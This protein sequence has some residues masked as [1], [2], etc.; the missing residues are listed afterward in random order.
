MDYRPLVAEAVRRFW[1]VRSRQQDQQGATT[2]R[3]D[4][5]NRTAVT[6]G[7]HLD[8]FID[9]LR[10]ILTDAGLPDAEVHTRVATLPGWFRPTK[11]WDLVVVSGHTLVAVIECK[12]HVGPSFGN[13]FNNRIEEALGSSTDL[14]AAWREGKF[15]PSARP[16][17]GWLML[18]EDTER[19]TSPVRL[20]EPHFPVFP[21]FRQTSYAERYAIF[22]QRLL[23]E[24]LYDGACLLLTPADEG[25]RSGAFSE[26]RQELGFRPFAT[27]LR[28]HAGA[29]A[30][31]RE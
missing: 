24:R 21:E 26:P 20:D 29:F 23:R 1:A 22:C 14:L 11:N 9:L 31:L 2:G 18:L 15:Q 3:R 17:L 27:G 12:A 5:G 10:R 4:A 8:G 25:L 28:A 30:A 13:N 7:R 16:W 6:G 19:A